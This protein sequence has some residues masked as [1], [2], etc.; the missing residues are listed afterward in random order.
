MKRVRRR[1][2]KRRGFRARQRSALKYRTPKSSGTSFSGGVFSL[3]GAFAVIMWARWMF[4]TDS[5]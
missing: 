4:S 3:A 5:D 1:R 2:T